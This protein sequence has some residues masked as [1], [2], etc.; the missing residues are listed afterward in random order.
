MSYLANNYLADLM[1]DMGDGFD[2]GNA[3]VAMSPAAGER[4]LAPSE[5]IELPGGIIMQKKT[6]WL[7]VGVIAAIALYLY[8]SRNKRISEPAA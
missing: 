3:T 5:M 8:T 4:Q 7:L 2:A 6:F 1:G